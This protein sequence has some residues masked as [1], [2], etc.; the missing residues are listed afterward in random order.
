MDNLENFVSQFSD[1]NNQVGSPDIQQQEDMIKIQS[2]LSLL[3]AEYKK[4]QHMRQH[5]EKQ[6]NEMNKL[7]EMVNTTFP[8]RNFS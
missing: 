7:V 1:D 3:Q 4:E 5:F 8:I 6:L 2:D